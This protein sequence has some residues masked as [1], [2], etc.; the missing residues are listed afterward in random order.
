MNF[1][2]AVAQLR[3]EARHLLRMS[4][5]VPAAARAVLLQDEKLSAYRARLTFL[6]KVSTG[7]LLFAPFPT[8]GPCQPSSI[9]APHGTICRERRLDRS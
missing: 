4:V 8:V 7:H 1:D 5:P 2:K 6:V 9:S 3:Q